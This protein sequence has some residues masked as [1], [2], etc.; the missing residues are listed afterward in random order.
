[1]HKPH[2]VVYVGSRTVRT[3]L[4]RLVPSLDDSYHAEKDNKPRT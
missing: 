2:H 4:G 1:V 3:Y